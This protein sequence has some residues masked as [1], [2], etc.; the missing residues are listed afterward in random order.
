MALCNKK[1]WKDAVKVAERLVK[2]RRGEIRIGVLF[3]DMESTS[4]RDTIWIQF[5]TDKAYI[6][7]HTAVRYGLIATIDGNFDERKQIGS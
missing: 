3:L 1:K 2:K 7:C 6:P 4:P 5:G